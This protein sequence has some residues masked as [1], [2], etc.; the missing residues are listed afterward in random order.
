MGNKC[1]SLFRIIKEADDVVR[2]KKEYDKKMKKHPDVDPQ[3]YTYKNYNLLHYASKKGRVNIVAYLCENKFDI[4]KWMIN[5]FTPLFCALKNKQT[6]AI[7]LLIDLGADVNIITTYGLSSLMLAATCS[8]ECLI[9]IMSRYDKTNINSMTI[10]DGYSALCYAVRY[11]T[12]DN[13]LLLLNN[14]CDLFHITKEGE[15]ILDLAKQNTDNSM[16][17]FLNKYIA[18]RNTSLNTMELP[19]LQFKLQKTIST[20][21]IDSIGNFTVHNSDISRTPRTPHK[22]DSSDEIIENVVINE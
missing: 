9:K 12:V 5:E 21:Q 13:C 2:F 7:M 4:D 6:D 16:V 18:S 14:D 1:G 20:N 15:N 22:K 17:E 8:I 11:S 3:E 10:S 19:P